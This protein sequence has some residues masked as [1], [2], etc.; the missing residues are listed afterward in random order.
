MG[1]HTSSE[2]RSLVIS[3]YKA[4]KSQREIAEIVGKSRTTVQYIIKRFK[5]SG[6]VEN[7]SRN[8][9]RKA[10]TPANERFILRIIRE[11][12]A[13]SAPKLTAEIKTLLN[14]D[15]NPETVRRVLKK[16][17]FNGRAARRKPHITEKNKKKRLDFALKYVTKDSSFWTKVTSFKTFQNS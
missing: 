8:S 17:G 11:N 3:H 12:P 9:T 1:K 7:K 2:I 15:V 16:N 13:L 14:I 5:E 10:L 6:R 4:G